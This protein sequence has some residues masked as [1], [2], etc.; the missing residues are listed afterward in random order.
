MMAGGLHWPLPSGSSGR[1]VTIGPCTR[2]AG[3][4][5]SVCNP[6]N[7]L[8]DYACD[9]PAQFINII[10]QF[11]NIELLWFNCHSI[12]AQ[13]EVVRNAQSGVPAG[14]GIGGARIYES[15]LSGFRYISNR[16]MRVESRSFAPHVVIDEAARQR[17]IARHAAQFR[18]QLPDLTVIRGEE[19]YN[20]QRYF[21]PSI[22]M[23][24]CAIG[25]NRSFCQRLATAANAFVFAPQVAQWG[26]APTRGPWRLHNP[27]NFFRPIGLYHHYYEYLFRSYPESSSSLS[28]FQRRLGQ[29][30]IA[31]GLGR[32]V[33]RHPGVIG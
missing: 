11:S 7:E 1:L 3:D 28:P 27:V 25:R 24:S 30:R 6:A 19:V 29:Q 32:G 23:R 14:I 33:G 18:Q 10:G 17:I 8:I 4:P 20:L 9:S 15:D 5:P 21:I 16:A 12:D 2:G 26:A 22:I 31:T 13:G